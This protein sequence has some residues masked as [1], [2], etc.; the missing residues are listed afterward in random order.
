[1]V[2]VLVSVAFTVGIAVVLIGIVLKRKLSRKTSHPVNRSD[3]INPL[4]STQPNDTLQVGY[5]I[6]Y[7]CVLV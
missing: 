3:R 5:I 6:L 2:I 1:M 7:L 4:M